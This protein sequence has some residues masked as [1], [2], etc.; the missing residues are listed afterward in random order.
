MSTIIE[1]ANQWILSR[2]TGTSSKTIW[3]VMM[4]AVPEGRKDSWDYDIPHDPDDFGRCH[5]LLLLIPEWKGRLSEVASEFPKW[6]HLVR[7]WDNLI[8]YYYNKPDE[9]YGYMKAL[10]VKSA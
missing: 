3:A 4:D 10:R 1:R 8:D 2:D 5:R 7:E 6:K 9:L